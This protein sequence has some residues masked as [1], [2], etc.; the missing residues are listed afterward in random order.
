MWLKHYI[1][2]TYKTYEA[3]NYLPYIADS[4][5]VSFQNVKRS[6]MSVGGML[7]VA[8]SVLKVLKWTSP[9]FFHV[10]Y[11]LWHCRNVKTT[12]VK[13]AK[14]NDISQFEIW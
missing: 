12:L 3:M 6:N 8:Y 5:K 13:K 11:A 1:H 10:Y 4:K 9:V 2:I 7:V 14:A